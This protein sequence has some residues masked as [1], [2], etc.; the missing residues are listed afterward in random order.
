[1]FGILGFIAGIVL[2][3]FAMHIYGLGLVMRKFKLKLDYKYSCKLLGLSLMVLIMTKLL[4]FAFPTLDPLVRL[5]IGGFFFFT[6]YFALSP[7]VGVI[8]IEDIK[9]FDVLARTMKSIYP[10]FRIIIRIQLW[11][12]NRLK[13]RKPNVRYDFT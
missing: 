9:N 3:S 7:I 12:V 2:S 6:S 4:L 11:L 1:L 10:L 5:V 13:T 8:N